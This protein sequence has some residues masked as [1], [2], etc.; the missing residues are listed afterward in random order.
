MTNRCGYSGHLAVYAG[1]ATPDL[2]VA[3]THHLGVPLGKLG[4]RRFPDTETHVQIEESSRGADVYV[5]Q[6]TGPSVNENIM[7]LLIILD[8]FRR[9]SAGRVTAIIPYY[10]YSR[11]E[12]KSTGREPITA[13]LVAD[14]LTTAGADRVVS[15][16]L[17]APAIQGF[18]NISMDHLT[19]VP[20][21]SQYLEQ[22]KRPDSIVV[23]PDV[24]RVKLAA[25][26]AADLRL[27]VAV[28]HKERILDH[29]A[30]VHAVIGD[31]RDRAPII[32]D[33]VISTG[34]TIAEAVRALLDAGARPEITVAATHGLFAG[35]AFDRLSD[36]TIAEI[37]V[38]DTVPLKQSPPGLTVTTLSV[39]SLLAEAISRLNREESI[40]ALFSP[41]ARVT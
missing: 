41:W 37:V 22:R 19:A 31:V 33:D 20:I 15:I 28:L 10:G 21:I 2:A 36:P 16:D 18:F 29:G 17:H 3:V 7:E 24:G 12:K 34:G 6:S 30:R 27:P 11:Q 14:L 39:A 25:H 35:P 38:T 26:Y 4:L 8:A 13:R 5:V 23:A 32:V 1:P 9:A 40:S